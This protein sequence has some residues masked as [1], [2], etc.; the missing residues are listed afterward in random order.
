MP[1]TDPAESPIDLAKR[2]VRD[3]QPLYAVEML[4]PWLAEYPEDA[5][6]KSVV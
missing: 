5:D 2:F 3:D 4:E 6:R 1:V